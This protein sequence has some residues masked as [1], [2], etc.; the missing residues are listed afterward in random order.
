MSD[1]DLY[2][3]LLK[4]ALSNFIYLGQDKLPHDYFVFD[5]SLYERETKTF[6]VRT[7][8]GQVRFGIKHEIFLNSVLANIRDRKLELDIFKNYIIE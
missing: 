1:T 8:D 4:R 5:E 7:S 2:L 3:D 6:A